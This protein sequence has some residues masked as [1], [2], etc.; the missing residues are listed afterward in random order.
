MAERQSHLFG[1]SR[2]LEEGSHLA[3]F[4]T[5]EIAEGNGKNGMSQPDRA[6]PRNPWP[7]GRFFAHSRS[8]ASSGHSVTLGEKSKS[9]TLRAK[10]CRRNC[11]DCRCRLALPRIEHRLLSQAFRSYSFNR[12][13]VDLGFFAVGNERH[14][15]VHETEWRKRRIIGRIFRTV[16]R[17]VRW[18]VPFSSADFRV[19]RSKNSTQDEST[20]KK[21]RRAIYSRIDNSRLRG[22]KQAEA[23]A[24]AI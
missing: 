13:A 10:E 12:G 21:R 24:E 23:V 14:L 16:H 19:F 18:T 3:V 22:A 2:F 15:N 17:T 8:W 11:S 20:T 9:A 4:F 6:A 5:T 7:I 1:S